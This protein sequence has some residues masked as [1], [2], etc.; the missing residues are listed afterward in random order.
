MLSI[1]FHVIWVPPE[2][3]WKS[4]VFKG[5]GG[6][7]WGNLVIWFL[8]SCHLQSPCSTDPKL[9]IFALLLYMPYEKQLKKRE[10]MLWNRGS[11]SNLWWR[12]ILLSFGLAVRWG[13]E[14]AHAREQERGAESDNPVSA[15]NCKT[16]TPASLGLHQVS[17]ARL[18]LNGPK[19]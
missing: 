16:K 19:C 7:G 12:S 3:S 18:L 6:V 15:S 5:R 13:T 11:E 17:A 1:V 9:V 8:V 10:G 2:S 14:G 4:R